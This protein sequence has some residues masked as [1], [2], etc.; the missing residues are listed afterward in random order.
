MA[1]SYLLPFANLSDYTQTGI[2]QEE[3]FHEIHEHL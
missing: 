1:F 2:G 3:K